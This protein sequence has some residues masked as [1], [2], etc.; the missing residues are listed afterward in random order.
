MALSHKIFHPTKFNHHTVHLVLCTSRHGMWKKAYRS[1]EEPW[2]LD[3]CNC[4]SNIEV[5]VHHTFGFFLVPTSFNDLITLN[6][7]VL[8][9]KP[10]LVQ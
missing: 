6:L 8:C 4:V 9:H 2:I 10:S 5:N 3:T 7:Q 1:Y